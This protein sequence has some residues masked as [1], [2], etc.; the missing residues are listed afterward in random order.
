M[1]YRSLALAGN[2]IAG[3]TCRWLVLIPQ[4]HNSSVNLGGGGGGGGGDG[5]D[6]LTYEVTKLTHN[7]LSILAEG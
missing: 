6:V 7:N 3:A 4:I 1:T 5:T 2:S